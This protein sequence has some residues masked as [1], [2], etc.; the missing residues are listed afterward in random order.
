MV[1][2]FGPDTTPR[3]VPMTRSCA[4]VQATVSVM[5]TS[6]GALRAQRMAGRNLASLEL[7]YAVLRR[8]ALR[9]IARRAAWGG[10]S[11]GGRW[12]LGGAHLPIV[13]ADEVVQDVEQHQRVHFDI[14][15]AGFLL[16]DKRVG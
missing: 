8:G 16:E 12:V 6:A 14:L 7:G 5:Q 15:D 9:V 4:T 13:P 3:S 11:R 1:T 2:L 10:C